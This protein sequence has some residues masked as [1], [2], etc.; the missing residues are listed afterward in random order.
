MIKQASTKTSF[1]VSLKNP[2]ITPP[3]AQQLLFSTWLLNIIKMNGVTTQVDAKTGH[4]PPLAKKFIIAQHRTKQG[5]SALPA[6]A[7]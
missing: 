4:V 2:H 3:N 7:A 5:L 6:P 1:R